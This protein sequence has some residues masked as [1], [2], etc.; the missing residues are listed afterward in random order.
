M[1]S[2]NPFLWFDTQAEDAANFYV[3]S[4]SS[5]FDVDSDSKNSK[6]LI[7]NRY[8]DAGPGPKGSVMIANFQLLGQ[9]FVALNGG[10]LKDFI[11]NSSISFFVNCKL[12]TE[13]SRLFKML[14]ENGK[15]LMPL[16]KYPFSEKFVWFND[17]F[18]VSW[19]LNFSK[20]AQNIIPFL[21]YENQ[22]EEA[23]NYYIS[24]FSALGKNKS[25]IKK[26]SRF[27][28]NENGQVGK[29]QHA[30]FSL[31]GQEYMAMDSNK[32]HF[33]PSISLFVNCESQNEVDFLWEKLSKEGK[34]GQCGWLTDKFG[35]TWQVVPKAIVKLMSDPDPKKSQ[36]VT[37]ALMKMTKIE[38]DD[39]IKAYNG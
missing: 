30:V 18:G 15:V 39:L 31:N 14:S 24:V 4:F 23:M 8:G 37:E 10:H 6:M 26:L 2:I 28:I 29:V 25:E 20:N 3:S 36:R 13:V 5:V 11:F 9:E 38:I 34:P 1:K 21:W 16:D 33:T 27:G 12:E 35:V 22:A 32:E 7:M 19:Q 17:K